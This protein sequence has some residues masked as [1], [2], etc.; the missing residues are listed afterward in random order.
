MKQYQFIYLY[1][2]IFYYY[3]FFK[4]IVLGFIYK[5]VP[6]PVEMFSFSPLVAATRRRDTSP[7][8]NISGPM[9]TAVNTNDEK[10]LYPVGP[11]FG[12]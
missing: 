12:M 11:K 3:F 5:C 9:G 10:R 8:L 6:Y 7:A 1:F 2:F 4:D